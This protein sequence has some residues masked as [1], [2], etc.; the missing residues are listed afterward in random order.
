MKAQKLFLTGAMLAAGLALRKALRQPMSVQDK[1]VVITGAAAGIGLATAHA[2]AAA[3]ARVVLVERRTQRLKQA[4]TELE[5]Y[6]TPILAINA[7]I[8]D[9]AALKNLI[10]ETMRVFGRIDI[11]VNNAGLGD[12]GALDE[13]DAQSL[14]AVLQT[15]LHGTFRLTQL[16]LPI[17]LEQKSGHIVFLSSLAAYVYVPGVSVYTA[18][19]A[20][21]S[22]FANCL[23]REVSNKGLRVSTVLPGVARTEM[24]ARL[25]EE[26]LASE[27][28]E[29]SG[30]MGLFLKMVDEPE[31][32]AQV[33]VDAV[34][35][36]KRNVLRGGPFILLM[37]SLERIA[38][39]LVDW[40]YSKIDVSLFLSVSGKLGA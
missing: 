1:V 22:A 25:F 29:Q 4:E 36:Q 3:G 7:D 39:G 10:S 18:T 32:L 38:P 24:T 31:T 17:M 35:Y 19:K 15:N 2:F 20:G 16:V 27:N 14:H 13:M 26:Y 9:D 11:L 6:G 28:G 12:G 33:I 34:R 8:T 40:V 30:M 37:M 5:R 21:I 23:R